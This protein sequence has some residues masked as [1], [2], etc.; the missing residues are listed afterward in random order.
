M[1]V[2]L[3]GDRLGSGK[4]NR[5][6]LPGHGRS[7]HDLG[8]IFKST[9]AAGTLVPF[10]CK[11]MLPGD[12]FDFNLDSEILTHPTI[13][14][15][16]GSF[17]AQYDAFLCPVRLYQGQLHNNKA[18]IGLTMNQVK[19]PQMELLAV[20]FDPT[21]QADLDNAQINPSC[22][23]KYLGIS[24]VGVNE[25]PLSIT[26]RQFN[27]LSLLMYWDIVKNY[28]MNK[29]EEI[30]AVIHTPQE[31]IIGID[32]VKIDGVPI[33]AFPAVQSVTLGN[34]SVIVIE[35]SGSIPLTY[36][37]I[38]HIS[39]GR[40]ISV[41]EMTQSFTDN[42]TELIVVYDWPAYGDMVVN[43]WTYSVATTPF[44][45]EPKVVTFPISEIDDMREYIMTQTASAGAVIINTPNLAPFKYVLGATA[46]RPHMMSTQEGLAVKTYQ[47]D[48][49]N[50]W[51]N[52]DWLDGTGGINEITSISTAAGSFTVD[53]FIL[54]K[55]M[56]DMLNR[57]AASDGTYNSWM[58]VNYDVDRAWQPIS[59]M[60]M[61]GLSKELVFQQV[62]SNSASPE[63][64]PLG[65]IAGKGQLT[66]KHKG[67]RFTIKA[68]EI[69]Y[70]IGI[71]SLTP[72]I[73]YS[74]GN[75]WDIHLKTMDDF[76][77][78][79]LDGI[80]FQELPT[81]RMAWWATRRNPVSP[82]D[83]LTTSAGKQPAWMEY[84][85]SV[86]KNFGNFAIKDNEMFMTNN[87]NYEYDNTVKGIKDLTT[88]IDPVKWNNIFAQTSRDAQ[89]FWMQ[90]GVDIM[91][92]RVMSTTVLPTL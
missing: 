90:I 92:R 67:G 2:T 27:A 57:V 7:N 30:G 82:F 65:T 83:W 86:N 89:N 69:S 66:N 53:A 22:V 23:L 85:T 12:E 42:G 19:L 52:T 1:K 4:R 9:M 71:V 16:F 40:R 34:G 21:A 39:D 6:N 44:N 68:D 15:L 50:N 62:V 84:R 35:Y 54:S 74:Q 51:M 81:E 38:F 5:I 11:V 18:G 77:K 91:A 48:I 26:T 29:Q 25:V 14:P 8:F 70:V 32:G 55:K 80:G 3:G 63:G 58:S 36:Q 41:A 13:G 24:G 59:P 28:Y 75:E 45:D 43:S 73:D 76:H 47:S 31:A 20:P 87:R 60:Y 61:G 64:Q 49:F 46:D 33:I 10:V 79:G 56:Y 78:P 17:K 72:R 37:I 88:Y